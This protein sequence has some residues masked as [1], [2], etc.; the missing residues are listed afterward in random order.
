MSVDDGSELAPRDAF[1]LVHWLMLDFT[2]NSR[3]IEARRTG[4]RGL[5]DQG[6]MFRLL[7]RERAP[8]HPFDWEE[9]GNRPTVNW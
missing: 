6:P 7:L 9:S 8:C 1:L 4:V 3:R 2:R 5:I